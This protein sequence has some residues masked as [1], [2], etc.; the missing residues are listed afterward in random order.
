MIASIVTLADRPDLTEAMRSM[1]STWPEFMQRDPVGNLFFGRLPEA[2]PE[3]QLLALDDRGS[4][5]G[6]VHSVP[7]LWHGTEDELP[8]RGWDGILER[9]FSDKRRGERPTAVSL[10]E[11]RLAPDHRGAGLSCE[12]LAAARRNAR[13]LGLGDLF[14]PVRPT[15]KSNEVRTPM[16][17]YAARLRSD[18]LPADPWLRV[19]VRLGGRIVK[20]CPLSMIV[21]GTLKD[22]RAWT[23]LPFSSSGLLAIPEALAPVHVSLEHDHAVYIEPNVWVHHHL[24]AEG[25]GA[26]ADSIA[27]RAGAGVIWP[28]RA[29]DP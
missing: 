23:G 10:I 18:G 29:S 26:E 1:P 24:P 9:A 27:T 25:G 2:F 28:N 15:G 14:G 11:A 3:H 7:F 19:H 13:R 4:I 22:W 5:V 21:P 6:K 8:E 20:V 16:F 17:E 12:L